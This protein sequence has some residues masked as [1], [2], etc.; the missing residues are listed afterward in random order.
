M[1]GGYAELDI[2]DQMAKT[3][4]RVGQLLND[5]W[6]RARACALKEGAAL[7]A[8]AE[9]HGPPLEGGL[10]AWDWRFYAELERL[11][12]YDFDERSIKPYLSLTN[13]TAAMFGCAQKLFGLR[14]I[15]TE[16]RGYCPD[17][18]VYEVRETVEGVDEL[19]GVFCVDNFARPNKQGGAWMSELRTASRDEER[20]YPVIY[21]NNNFTRGDPC[22]LTFDDAV[23]AFHEFGHGLHGL[24]SSATYRGLAGTSVLKDFV[25][26]PSQLFEHWISQ[27]VVLRE[28]ATHCVTGEPL[29]EALLE[30]LKAAQ[31]YGRGF[32][33]VEYTAC[34]LLDQ[35]LHSLSREELKDLD[36]SE[37]ERASLASLGMPEAI[38]LRH[39][40]PHFD[41]LF[42]GS[43]YASG[44]YVYLWAEVLDADAFE[45]F[46]ETGDVFSPEFASRARK[47][48]YGAGNTKDPEELFQSFR[49]R[50]PIIEPMLKKKGLTPESPLSLGL[51]VN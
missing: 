37:F 17:V 36:V 11:E 34:A 8:F 9:K 2:S 14:F 28:Y 29:P 12:C 32:A 30:K 38:P 10:K 46:K 41:H 33:T 16:E 4:E 40:L 19:V 49:G 21:N 13:V 5:V 1:W 27:P 43:S 35:T 42:G 6:P 26:L 50:A 3:P 25:E 23:T 22:L 24:L 20:V 39:R 45:A 15:Q 48:F 31:R 18:V 7:A 51:Q 47:F 44:Y